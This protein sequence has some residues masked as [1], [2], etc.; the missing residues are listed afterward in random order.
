MRWNDLYV[1]G[2]GAWLP[3]T[4]S[5]EEAVA[6]GRYDEESAGRSGHLSVTVAPPEENI[7]EMAVRAGQQALFRS[8][9]RPEDVDAVFY[10]VV[11]HAGID[12]WNAASYIQRGVAAAGCFAAEVRA[13]SNGGLMS[14]ELAAAYLASR[15]GPRVAVA[16]AGD[17]WSEPYF[18]RWRA[19]RIL[20]GDGAAAI[21]LST[22]QGFARI[23]SMATTTDPDLEAMHRGKQPF[24]PFQHDVDR[25][26]DLNQRHQDFL[27]TF[28]KD[29]VW[30]R[31][32][33]GLQ[34]AARQALDEAEVRI[35]D[36]DHVVVPHFGAGLTLRQ[37][38]GPIGISELSRTPWDFSRRTG[39]LGPADQFAGLNHL[40][41][42]GALHAGQ[43]VLLVGVGGG[44][45]WTCTV[46]EV[47]RTPDWAG[48]P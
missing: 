4:V 46:L 5:V 32:E 7:A 3:K 2:L 34:S 30:R 14:V 12:I 9:Y 1:A 43:R 40:A 27:E 19:D 33:A 10:S 13:G 29:E 6:Q 39:H 44:F 8:G 47:L 35:A 21:A 25:P 24:G 28:D 48:R 45:S 18:D 16:T 38:L 37:C 20:Y 11:F 26:I 22:E 42:T 23:I 15:P 31:V 17:L 36:I 41:E